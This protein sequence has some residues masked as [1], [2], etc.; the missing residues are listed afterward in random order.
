MKTLIDLRCPSCGAALQVGDDREFIYCEYCGTKILI[1]DEN[2]YTYHRIDDAAIKRAETE[3]DIAMKK[4]EMEEKKRADDKKRFVLKLVI[5]AILI[6]IG[7]FMIASGIKSSAASK[8]PD[9]PYEL[10]TA[11]G[12]FPI[13]AVSWIWIFSLV[14]KDDSDEGHSKNVEVPFEVFGYQL[15]NYTAIE[16]VLKDAGF[17][18][19]KCVPLNDLSPSESSVAGRVSS[20]TI[21][22]QNIASG[23]KKFSSDAAVVISY[24]NVLK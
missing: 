7:I 17:K 8:D 11:F 15:K 1:N 3:R 22:G 12:V 16:S 2:K 24:H 23:G 9:S 21:G 19:V 6:G 14:K 10:L 13:L 5:S 4:L 20:I 18:N